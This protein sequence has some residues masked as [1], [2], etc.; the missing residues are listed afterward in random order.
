MSFVEQFYEE[1]NNRIDELFKLHILESLRNRHQRRYSAGRNRSVGVTK[2]EL[3]KKSLG[4]QH[5]YVYSASSKRN[6]SLRARIFYA[7][8][9]Q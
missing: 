6:S 9:E 2:S 8:W 4:H 5:L 1:R 7:K 3:L